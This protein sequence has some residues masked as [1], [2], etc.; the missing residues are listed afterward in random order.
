MRSRA[1]VGSYEQVLRCSDEQVCLPDPGLPHTNQV[2]VMGC[3]L[4]EIFYTKLGAAHDIG[5]VAGIGGIPVGVEG[6]QQVTRFLECER[7]VAEEA[8]IRAEE[9]E[10][11]VEDCGAKLLLV[12]RRKVIESHRD[13]LLLLGV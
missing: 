12:L 11:P 3:G 10:G 9:R 2:P 8:P 1:R 4:P 5:V 13:H 7:A 6:V